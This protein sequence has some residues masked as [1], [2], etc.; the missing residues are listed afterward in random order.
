MKKSDW[1]Y[2]ARAMW[3]YSEKHEGRISTLLKQLVKEIN[4]NKEMITNDMDEL[5]ETTTSNG[6]IEADT[7]D[8]DVFRGNGE[9]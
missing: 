9:F 6:Q 4:N 1:D 3:Q 2:L 5:S 7:N 8:K